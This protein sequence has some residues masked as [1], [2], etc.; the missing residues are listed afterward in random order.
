MFSDTQELANFG[1]FALGIDPDKSTEA[2]WKKAAEKLK[3]QKRDAGIVRK[4]YDQDYIDA[5]RQG[6]RVDHPGLVG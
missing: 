1:M 5:P 4:Y 6:R 3:E 2:D